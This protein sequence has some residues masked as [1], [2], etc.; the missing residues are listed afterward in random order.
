MFPEPGEDETH[1]KIAK[2]IKKQNRMIMDALINQGTDSNKATL[3]PQ[4]SNM[5]KVLKSDSRAH[6]RKLLEKYTKEKEDQDRK[7]LLTTLKHARK[8]QYH[9]NQELM[10]MQKMQRTGSNMTKSQ[11]QLIRQTDYT[12]EGKSPILENI[13]ASLNSIEKIGLQSQMTNQEKMALTEEQLLQIIEKCKNYEINVQK[14][15]VDLKYIQELRNCIDDFHKLTSIV[16]AKRSA[17][18]DAKLINKV[19]K[20]IEKKVMELFELIRKHKYQVIPMEILGQLT[21]L[22]DFG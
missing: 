13:D 10:V 14:F 8:S 17:G 21:A 6:S 22:Q 7:Q 3:K 11:L 2:K 15:K 12:A 4:N 18:S 1:P 19:S 9:K 20:Q 16:P 5:I